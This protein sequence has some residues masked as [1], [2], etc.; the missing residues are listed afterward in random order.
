MV[1]QVLVETWKYVFTTSMCFIRMEVGIKSPIH[2]DNEITSF[3][4]GITIILPFFVLFL[5]DSNGEQHKIFYVIHW[6]SNIEQDN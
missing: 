2:D 4:K 6:T 3:Y 5:L 1:F